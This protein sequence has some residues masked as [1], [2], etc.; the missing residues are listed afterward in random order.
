MRE[1]MIYNEINAMAM[2]RQEEE[3]EKLWG[4]KA[5]IHYHGHY[6]IVEAL[7]DIKVI[8]ALVPH[9]PILRQGPLKK[10]EFRTWMYDSS[11]GGWGCV[12]FL[13]SASRR[14]DGETVPSDFPDEYTKT[15]EV[16]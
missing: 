10:G 5:K 12:S 14:F 8:L 3:I 7:Q 13:Q 11:R 4:P 9:C 16:L 6:T 1:M 15:I 2:A